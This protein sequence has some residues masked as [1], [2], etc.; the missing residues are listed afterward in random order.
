MSR[1]QVEVRN[2]TVAD[3]PALVRM[4]QEMG[5]L[6]PRIARTGP[7]ATPAN[8]AELLATVGADPRHRLLVAV[9]DGEPAGVAC[10]THQAYVPLH[11]AG[12]VHVTYL[13]VSSA[14][15]RRGV[16]HALVGAAMGFADEVGAE[17]LVA[18]VLPGGRESNRFFARLGLGPLS[19]QR[20]AP[21]AVLRRRLAVRSAAEVRLRPADD[22]MALRR[23][24]RS[25][26]RFGP[27][28]S[29]V[30]AERE[31]A[32]GPTVEGAGTAG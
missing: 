7:S 32:A 28:D 11:E 9:V 13:H 4:W 15:R 19:V 17:H 3:L 21:V 30:L 8:A 20:A 31:P 26:G 14:Y 25:R 24:L 5:E 6:N 10:L 2:A 23:S 29:A 22:L 18:S 12:S 27:L 16:G 1:P